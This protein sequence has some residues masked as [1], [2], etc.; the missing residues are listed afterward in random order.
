M[1]FAASEFWLLN[2]RWSSDIDT[3][4]VYYRMYGEEDWQQLFY[5]DQNHETW[6][7]VRMQLPEEIL[8]GSF[9]IKFV[10]YVRHGFGIGLDDIHVF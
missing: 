6:T 8:A 5:T 2:R 7:R 10:S 1:D 3:L 4:G 9:Q